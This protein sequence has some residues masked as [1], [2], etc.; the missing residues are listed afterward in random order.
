MG[1]VL[2]VSR[3]VSRESH[4]WDRKGPHRGRVRAGGQAGA[5]LLERL[6]ALPASERV[7]RLA[8]LAGLRLV[9]GAGG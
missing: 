3:G 8:P 1:L 6:R 7:L 9:A 2:G 4:P 5:V